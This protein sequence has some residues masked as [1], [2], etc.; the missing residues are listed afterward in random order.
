MFHERDT[1][2]PSSV[3]RRTHPG[4]H[5]RVTRKGPSQLATVLY[6]CY[7]ALALA[8]GLLTTEND[9]TK[10]LLAY[11]LKKRKEKRLAAGIGVTFTPTDLR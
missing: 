11:M 1:D 10:I 8:T 7:F 5:T 9:A 6:D 2:S 3:A 4:R